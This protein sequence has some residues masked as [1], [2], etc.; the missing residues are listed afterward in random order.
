M[1]ESALAANRA[2]HEVTGGF[3]NTHIR[4]PLLAAA[5]ALSLLPLGA[6][7]A[8]APTPISDADAAALRGKTAAVT[9]HETPSFMAMTAGKAGFGLLGVAGMV[10]AGNDFVKNNEIPDPSI[11]LRDRL[12]AL[13]QDTYGLQVKPADT[14]MTEEKKPAKIAALHAAD[15]DVVLSVRSLGWN[16][17]YYA[18]DW[19][20]YW[21]GYAAE[22]QL[23][24]AKTGK[25][26]SQA[27]CGANTQANPIK[28]TLENL[29]A[30]RAQLTKDIFNGLGWLCVQLLAKDQFKIPQD[31]IP[32]IPA[33]Y[34]NPLLRL[35]PAGTPAAAPAA[36]ATPAAAPEDAGTAAPAPTE[37]APEQP[38]AGAPAPTPTATTAT[39]SDTP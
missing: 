29:R 16:Y 8:K 11:L 13:L 30:D 3:L 15:A 18:T 33:E 26:M 14:T 21:V 24:D 23:V 1:L 10:K 32:A 19:S 35:Q 36:S 28:P 5:M 7:A 17:G 20:H 9:L 27:V 2:A 4:F 31:K 6:Q 34:V 38:A 22:V 39:G 37:P 12:G 25:S